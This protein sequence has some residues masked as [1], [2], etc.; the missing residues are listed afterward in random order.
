[1]PIRLSFSAL[2]AAL[3]FLTS[4]PVSGQETFQVGATTLT[5]SNVASGIQIPWELLWGP[6]DHL[7]VTSRAGSVHRID[8]ETGTTSTVL[9]KSVTNNGNGEPGMLGMAMHPDWENTPKVFVVYTSGSSWNGTEYLSVFDWNGSGLVNEEVLLS[10]PA[11]GI[12]NGSRLLVL[13]DNTLLMS[14]GDKGDGGASSQNFNSLNGKILRLNLDGSIPADNPTAGSYVYSIGHRNPQGLAMGPNGLIYSSEHGQ[15]NNDEVNIIQPGRNYGWPNVEGVCNTS[16]E[17]SFCVAN[18]VVEPI[19]TFSPCAAV[20]GMTWYNHPAIPEW[21]N[22]ILLS[23]MGGFALDDKRLSVLSLSEDG[24]T[25]TNE[26]Q[27]FASY[28]Q[29]LRDVAVNPTTGAVYVAFN[30]SSYPGSGPNVI[31]EFRNLDYVPSAAVAGCKYPGALNYNASATDDDGTCQFAGCTD[32]EALN[33]VPWANV[34][35]DCIY[36]APCAVDVDADGATT[37]ADLLLVL[38]AFG[39]LCD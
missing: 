18:N 5:A 24:T 35:T 22:S 12:H 20:N 3:L 11:A 31:K 13:P 23:V 17:N 19:D 37:V 26:T 2:C 21:Q 28:G 14:T 39:D 1:M 33:Y 30:G 4:N 38:G 36:Q 27:H 10:L 6:D 15:S 32:T 25:V 34:D 7:W 29:R 9:T 16:S 8:P